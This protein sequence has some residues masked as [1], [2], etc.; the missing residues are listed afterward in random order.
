MGQFLSWREEVSFCILQEF[1][2]AQFN[3]SINN[4]GRELIAK[5]ILYAEDINSNGSKN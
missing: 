4:L 2:L 5:L 3:V 1:V